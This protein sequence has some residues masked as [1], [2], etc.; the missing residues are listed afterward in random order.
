MSQRL[1]IESIRKHEGLNLKP[2]IDPLYKK[3]IPKD[4]LKIINKH[5]DKLNITIGYGRNLQTN[6]INEDEANSLLILDI[7]IIQK[8]L[9]VSFGREFF[10]SFPWYVQNVLIEMV[11]QLGYQGFSKFKKT[12]KYLEHKQYTLAS[13]EMLLSKWA[14][15]TPNRAKELSNLMKGG[16]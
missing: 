15:Q 2:Y 5:W 1:L 8:Q 16:N 13:K 4:D 7:S 14:E 11:Y 3:D 6:G 10:N 12:I 9:E